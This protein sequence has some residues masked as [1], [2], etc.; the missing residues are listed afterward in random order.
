MNTMTATAFIDQLV[1]RCESDEDA[2][3]Q[4]FKTHI[5]QSTAPE[6]PEAYRRRRTLRT[7]ARRR[8]SNASAMQRTLSHTGKAPNRLIAL[9]A[10]TGSTPAKVRPGLFI[11]G[12]PFERALNAL[13]PKPSPTPPPDR[14]VIDTDGRYAKAMAAIKPAPAVFTTVA[15]R[16]AATVYATTPPPAAPRPAPVDPIHAWN[17]ALK[18]MTVKHKGDSTRAVMELVKTRPD[19][20]QRYLDAVNQRSKTR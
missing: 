3:N 4:H 13:N 17:S 5:Q 10:A 9:M 8:T 15:H 14:K 18:E 2:M 11:E 1:N 12:G 16:P 19:L 6:A 7:E 20:Q